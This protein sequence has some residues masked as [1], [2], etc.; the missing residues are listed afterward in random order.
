MF[1]FKYDHM[2]ITLEEYNNGLMCVPHFSYSRY[3]FQV[4][5]VLFSKEDTLVPYKSNYA[6]SKCP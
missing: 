1:S 6:A 5:E 2:A 3:C 4:Y